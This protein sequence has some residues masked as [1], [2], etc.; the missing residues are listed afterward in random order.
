MHPYV[1][2][3]GMSSFKV[4]EV[5]LRHFVQIYSVDFGHFR[6][7]LGMFFFYFFFSL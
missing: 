1:G 5:L 7:K 6:L 2:H 3:V 4:C